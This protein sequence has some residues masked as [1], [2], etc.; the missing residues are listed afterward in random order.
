MKNHK[1]NNQWDSTQMLSELMKMKLYL[2]N[3]T[4]GT[5]YLKIRWKHL[6]FNDKENIY[7]LKESYWK[8]LFLKEYLQQKRGLKPLFAF[9]PVSKIILTT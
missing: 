6:F 2:G 7:I 3:R 1:T 9:T 5:I 8:H 4:K